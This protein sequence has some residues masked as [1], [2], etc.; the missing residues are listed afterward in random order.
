MAGPPDLEHFAFA[1]TPDD[2]LRQVNT[3]REAG[4][5]RIEFGSPP[6]H[7]GNPKRASPARRARPAAHRT[8]TTCR[9]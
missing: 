9:R 5:S 6:R 7:R 1:G 3:L 8:M 2:I 4:V